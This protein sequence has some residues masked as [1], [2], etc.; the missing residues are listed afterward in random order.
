MQPLSEEK[1]RN[2]CLCSKCS[3]FL[4][5]LPAPKPFPPSPN[6]VLASCKVWLWPSWSRC[7]IFAYNNPQSISASGPL[8]NSDKML[9]NTCSPLQQEAPQFNSTWC[10]EPFPFVCDTCEFHLKSPA[11]CAGNDWTCCLLIYPVHIAHHFTDVHQ[12]PFLHVI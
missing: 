8:F 11:C 7:L 10:L 6:T 2:C 9:I 12:I 4:F 1:T 3:Q 5:L